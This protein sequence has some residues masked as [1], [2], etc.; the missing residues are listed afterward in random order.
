VQA[1]GTP[2]LAAGEPMTDDVMKCRLKPLRRTDYPVTFTGGQ[3][4]R[5]QQAFPGGVCDYT[6]RG[7]SQTGAVAWLT[8]QNAKGHAVYG[9]RPL[10]KAPA[11][12]PVPVQKKRR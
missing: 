10:G 6:K 9:G 4:A 3:W 1:Y 12:R 11:S 2:R 8:Y 7:V 5:L